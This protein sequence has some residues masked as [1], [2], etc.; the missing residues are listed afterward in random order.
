[1]SRNFGCLYLTLQD[2][3]GLRET[4]VPLP[5]NRFQAATEQFCEHLYLAYYGLESDP[6]LDGTNLEV[7][8]EEIMIINN[9]LSSEDGDWAF[10]LLYQTRQ[11]LY[12]LKTGRA[13][14]KLAPFKE[15]VHL[16]NDLAEIDLNLDSKS[17]N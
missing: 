6:D 15:T 10:K 1:M 17:V 8:I 2:C 7:T 9:C 12:E 5:D 4:V 13:A 16:F 3:E 14:I 11:A